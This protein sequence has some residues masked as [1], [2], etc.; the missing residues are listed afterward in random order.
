MPFIRI[1]YFQSSVKYLLKNNFDVHPR[2]GIVADK[3][4]FE[5]AFYSKDG[6][7]TYPKEFRNSSDDVIL[8]RQVIYINES[9]DKKITIDAEMSDEYTKGFEETIA[10]LKSKNVDVVFFLCPYPPVIWDYIE[11]SGDFPLLFQLEEYIMNYSKNEGIDIVGSYNP[12]DA[13]VISSDFYD[14]RHLKAEVLLDKFDFSI[15]NK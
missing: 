11:K 4:T 5:G 14:E 12:Y 7:Y 9:L 2:A 15:V 1:N 10:Y 6:S 8:D 13:D 3:S